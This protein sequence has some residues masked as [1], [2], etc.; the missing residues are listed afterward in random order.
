MPFIGSYGHL[1]VID[2]TQNK[3]SFGR[4]FLSKYLVLSLIQDDSSFLL[5]HNIFY[6]RL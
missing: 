5:F 6:A 4:M 3:A 1:P 2:Q